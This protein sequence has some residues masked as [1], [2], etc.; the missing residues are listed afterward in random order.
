VI[1]KDD[2]TN[3][4]TNLTVSQDLIQNDNA[5]TVVNESPVAFGGYKYFVDN[6]IPMIGGGFDANE[7]GQPGNEDLVSVTGNQGPVFGPVYTNT[8]LPYKKLGATRLGA[9]GYSISPSSTAAA[10]N[11]V[12]YAA[13]AVGLKGVYTNTTL[14]FGTVDVGPLVLAMKNAGV[15]GISL[16]LDANTN[17]AVIA[18]AQQQ[19][20]NLKAAV[21]ATGYGQTLLDEPVSKTVGPEVLV[22]APGAPVELKTSAT[23]KFQSDL[24]KYSHYTGVPEF[25][26][27]EGYMAADL[28]IKGLQKAGQDPTR[29][30][31]LDGIHNMGTYDGGGLACQPIDVSLTNYGKTPPTSCGWVLQIKNGKFVPYPTNGK[32]SKG[33]LIQASVQGS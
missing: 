25:P 22:A 27:Y 31:F 32:P 33:T 18:A 7:Y 12:K 26:H 2:Q 4:G 19:G 9:L 6:N 1:V 3:P 16:P 30:S 15:D 21:L 20:L 17:F 24:K 8:G 28:V 29:Q 11:F 10:V 13:P 23:K 14:P 5:F